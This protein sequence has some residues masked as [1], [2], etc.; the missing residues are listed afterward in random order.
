[1]LLWQPLDEPVLGLLLVLGHATRDPSQ[2]DWEWDRRGHLVTGSSSRLTLPWS[3]GSPPSVC[4]VPLVTFFPLFVLFCPQHLSKVSVAQATRVCL[5]KEISY[6][7]HTVCLWDED[8]PE[9][10]SFSSSR[11]P[12]SDLSTAGISLAK[13]TGSDIDRISAFSSLPTV[14]LRQRSIPPPVY[15]LRNHLPIR[16]RSQ[17]LSP[18]ALPIGRNPWDVF[19]SSWTPSFLA[20]AGF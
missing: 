12:S 14:H 13:S 11:L 6:M 19:S 9:S 3:E 10:P 5:L 2:L 15:S 7:R 8:G 17:P 4:I 18:F 16:P 1:M 20:G